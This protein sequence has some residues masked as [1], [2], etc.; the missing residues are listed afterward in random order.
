[1]D[2]YVFKENQTLGPFFRE[3]LVNEIHNGVLNANDLCWCD[4]M[5][6]WKPLGEVLADDLWQ[7]PETEVAI[8]TPRSLKWL[9]LPATL[10]VVGIGIYLLWHY[11][12]QVSAPLSQVQEPAPV[13]TVEKIQPTATPT[14]A[15]PVPSIPVETPETS[16][17]PMLAVSSPTPDTQPSAAESKPREEVP[18][19]ADKSPN[20]DKPGEAKAPDAVNSQPT[21]TDA[22]SF[23]LQ[24]RKLDKRNGSKDD[25]AQA[26]EL[27]RKSIDLGNTLAM[28]DLA[29]LLR[30]TDSQQNQPEIYALYTRAAALGNP[31]ALVA[32]ATKASSQQECLSL[33]SKAA[34]GG[35]ISACDK[36]KQFYQGNKISARLKDSP[37]PNLVLALQ[38]HFV[39]EFLFRHPL[40]PPQTLISQMSQDDIQAARNG[41]DKFIEAH[42]LKRGESFETKSLKIAFYAN[43]E[44]GADV[45][46]PASSVSANP[47][48]PSPTQPAGAPEAVAK[49]ETVALTLEKNW[50]FHFKQDEKAAIE[51]RDLLA[52]SGKPNVDLEPHPQLTIYKSVTYLMPFN[53]AVKALGLEK[54]VRSKNMVGCPGWPKSSFG[55]FSFDGFFDGHFNRLLLIVD[56][57]EQVVGVELVDESPKGRSDTVA[58]KKDHLFTY[59]FI[60][61][62]HRVDSTCYVAQGVEQSKR[63]SSLQIDSQFYGHKT[64]HDG[65]P[66]L[67]EDVRL[68]LPQPMVDLI[69]F[70]AQ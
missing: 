48:V 41:A 54:Q 67:Q 62:Q 30:R 1:M 10:A 68:Y 14:P 3:Y 35:S 58:R 52:R 27:Y 60:Q 34:E 23:Y 51:L 53:A 39:F 17:A 7:E 22:E 70:Y 12:G 31:R 13:A 16:P 11:H 28:L 4:G 47:V 46:D 29:D 36:L 18:V 69:L 21:P 24:A 6:D 32:A 33:L 26:M 20:T 66:E 25:I 38:W 57:A 9:L 43:P 37:Q 44:A 2:I 49:P 5:T 64:S 65:P 45:P 63:Y 40:S 50:K 59:D 56:R 61:Y 42:G 55:Y 15:P 8:E 19:V